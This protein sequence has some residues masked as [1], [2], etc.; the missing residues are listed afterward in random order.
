MY[1]VV[2]T[3][4]AISGSGA[5]IRVISGAPNIGS[6]T[7]V[8]I[9]TAYFEA[10]GTSFI[11]ARIAAAGSADIS[12]VELYEVSGNAGAGYNMLNT[13]FEGGLI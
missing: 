3:I 12:S 13:S 6:F 5:T 1:K 9:H 8:G 4:A 7:T 2:V 11:L 10:G